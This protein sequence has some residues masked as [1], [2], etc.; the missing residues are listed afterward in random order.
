MKK[1]VLGGVYCIEWNDASSDDGEWSPKD[2]EIDLISCLSVGF[3][4]RKTKEKIIIIQ[5][6]SDTQVAS[7]LAIPRKWIKKITRMSKF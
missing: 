5:T 3:L 6:Y 4:H 7:M 2:A 1:L